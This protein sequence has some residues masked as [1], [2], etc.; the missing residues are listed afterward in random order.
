MSAVVTEL[1][2]RCLLSLPV[3]CS[4]DAVP[5]NVE[6]VSPAELFA[7]GVV[8]TEA[9]D[10]RLTLSP[11]GRT[12]AWFTRNRAGGPGEYDIWISSR[13]P[14]GWG[15]AS[16]APF[17]SPQRDFDPA[18]SADGR[19]IYF[20][21]N[22]SGGLGGDD[23]YRVAVLADG[24]G[25]V[26]HL[27]ANVNSAA[28]EWAPMLSPDGHKLLFS[29][30]GRGARRFDLF[31]SARRPDDS[32]DTAVP[33]P[34][35]INTA[36]DE[37]DAT[38]LADNVTVVFARSPNLQTDRVTLAYS[39]L[40]SDGYDAGVVLPSSVNAVGQN[41]YGPMLDWS[42]PS[43]LTLSSQRPEARAGSTDIYTFKYR[44]TPVRSQKL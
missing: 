34:G 11:D 27:G 40:R 29:S 7:P 17:N 16:P 36:A 39:S 43:R 33:L 31:V 22:R 4:T 38:F 20:C 42:D 3:I 18:F 24:F 21:S 41:T 35:A 9:S 8:S 25:A 6:V 13:T 37:F 28:D 14:G 23:L 26:E 19:F 1:A 30:N 10:V 5:A 32:F 12:A 44:L 2:T 15:A